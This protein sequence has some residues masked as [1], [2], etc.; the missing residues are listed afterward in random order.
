MRAKT[1]LT[2][3]LFVSVAFDLA[4]GAALWLEKPWWMIVVYLVFGA[5]SHP[6]AQPTLRKWAEQE[7]LLASMKDESHVG[8]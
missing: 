4:A 2:V 8:N 5:F 1:M 7:A 3:S 6:G